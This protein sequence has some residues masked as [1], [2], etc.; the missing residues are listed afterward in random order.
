MKR[1]WERNSFDLYAIRIIS[2]HFND[3]ETYSDSIPHSQSILKTNVFG[4]K[5]HRECVT[6]YFSLP[7]IMDSTLMADILGSFLPLSPLPTGTQL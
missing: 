3:P 2:I 5:R 4:I 6:I 1:N 7:Q